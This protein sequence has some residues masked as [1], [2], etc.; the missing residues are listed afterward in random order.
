VGEVY[1]DAEESILDVRGGFCTRRH[2][3]L[4]Y[5][6]M[7]YVLATTKA[8]RRIDVYGPNRSVIKRVAKSFGLATKLRRERWEKIHGAAASLKVAAAYLL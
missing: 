6:G 7:D 5:N 1:Q 2:V 3:D 8:S 4:T